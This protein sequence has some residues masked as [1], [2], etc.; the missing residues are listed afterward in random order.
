MPTSE[1]QGN[2]GVEKKARDQGCVVGP[3]VPPSQRTGWP[4]CWTGHHRSVPSAPARRARA[5]AAAACLA[6]PL[7]HVRRGPLPR[8]QLRSSPW[9]RLLEAQLQAQSRTHEEEAEALRAQVE[10]LK[11]ELDRQQQTFSQTLLLAPEAQVEF[12]VQ[13]EMS[14]LTNENLVSSR[15][16]ADPGCGESHPGR[17]RDQAWPSARWTKFM[18]LAQ[19]QG[20]SI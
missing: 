20:Q 11:E 4:A 7:L 1:E 6:A 18:P 15:C 13:Q 2:E 19:E 14:R 3:G 8:G 17:Q 12:A 10:A 5:V 9:C 16:P